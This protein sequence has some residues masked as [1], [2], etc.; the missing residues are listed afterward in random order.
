MLVSLIRNVFN[1]VTQKSK[2]LTKYA[3]N[4][5]NFFLLYMEEYYLISIAIVVQQNT[6]FWGSMPPKPP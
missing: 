3:S 5:A 1:V 2:Y 6:F 4:L